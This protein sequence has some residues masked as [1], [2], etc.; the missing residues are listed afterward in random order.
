MFGT[1]R[2]KQELLARAER[3]NRETEH[4]LLHLQAQLQREVDGLNT[5]IRVLV[6]SK[7]V[8]N[9][10]AKLRR[11]ALTQTRLNNVNARLEVIQKQLDG[12]EETRLSM[13][14]VNGAK[15]TQ[16]ALKP[17]QRGNQIKDASDTLANVD[18]ALELVQEVI[19]ITTGPIGSE[20]GIDVE[21]ELAAMQATLVESQ[22]PSLVPR[23]SPASPVSR[24]RP[25]PPTPQL[26]E[27]EEVA[28]AL[29]LTL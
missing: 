2:A 6:Q 16:K 3:Q 23:A 9:A 17:L 25:P 19:D 22:M 20:P 27:E 12:L 15:A 8:E 7:Q 5:Q 11:R 4:E 26:T 14:M 29:T 10:R 18:D 1:T 24:P 13:Q 28:M 21:E